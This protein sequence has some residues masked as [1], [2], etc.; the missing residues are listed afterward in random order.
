MRHTCIWLFLAVTA[1]V[2]LAVIDA[3][4]CVAEEPPAVPPPEGEQTVTPRTDSDLGD[5][6]DGELDAGGFDSAQLDKTYGGPINPGDERCWIVSKKFKAPQGH[7]FDSFKTKKDGQ[8]SLWL[9][10]IPGATDGYPAYVHDEEVPDALSAFWLVDAAAVPDADHFTW[11]VEGWLKGEGEGEGQRPYWAAQIFKPALPAQPTFMWAG[12]PQY[13]Y[14]SE[15]GY[16][17]YAA[18][19]VIVSQGVIDQL[20]ATGGGYSVTKRTVT[21]YDENGEVVGGPFTAY[22]GNLVAADTG[23]EGKE[24][25]R[26]VPHMGGYYDPGTDPKYTGGDHLMWDGRTALEYT[27]GLNSWDQPIVGYKD[28][29]VT[30]ETRVFAADDEVREKIKKSED[31][32]RDQLSEQNEYAH[33]HEMYLGQENVPDAWEESFGGTKVADLGCEFKVCSE[34]GWSYSVP[35]ASDIPVAKGRSGYGTPYSGASDML[36]VDWEE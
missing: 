1:V 25:N 21:Y 6:A 30:M 12:V 32:I 13:K 2:S 4:L 24:V 3:P 8:P 27:V 7:Q 16:D 31:Q 19:W 28:V 18:L 26:L 33:K 17:I 35:P 14:I 20:A 36:K 15:V 5:Q 29:R 11:Y 34:P 23:P 9:D 22:Y 10:L